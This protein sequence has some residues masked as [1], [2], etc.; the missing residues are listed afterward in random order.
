MRYLDSSK[1][2]FEQY[3]K[4]LIEQNFPEFVGR[5]A[6]GL[7]GRGSECFGY[8][9][10]T[11]LDH[12]IE[13]GFCLWL[14]DEDYEICCEALDEAYDS[15]PSEFMGIH[16]SKSSLHHD[17]RKG[18]FS[19]SSFYSELIGYPDVPHN[20]LVW[21]SIPQYAL[22]EAT[23]GTIF[24]DQYGEFTRIRNGLLRY[25]P[26]D[27][28]LVKL[29]KCF[30]NMAQAGQYNFERCLRH[31]ENGAAV[32][33]LDTFVRESIRAAFLINGRFCPY[34]KWALRALSEIQ[35]T[36]T[37]CQSLDYLLTGSNEGNSIVR[38]INAIERVSNM[39]ITWSRDKGLSSSSSDYL[40]QHAYQIRDKVKDEKLQSFNIFE[41]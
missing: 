38:K 33:A 39:F 34:Y 30:I 26:Q 40:E 41:A 28:V 6:A 1:M 10:V 14:L 29:S 15:L 11:S 3:G 9:D 20:N 31:G 32:L 5:Y 2:F 18:V 23:N 35:G 4:P 27:V 19:I 17:K 21:T 22:A 16:L 13:P 12:D 25:Y 37:L 8:E 36:S 24:V 7:V